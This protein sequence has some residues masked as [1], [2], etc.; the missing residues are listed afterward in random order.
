MLDDGVISPVELF[1]VNPAGAAVYVPPEKAPVPVKVTDAEFTVVQKG[2]PAYEMVAVGTA[3]M[4]TDAVAVTAAQPPE[5]A[6]VY[7]TV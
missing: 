4:I 5:A 1:I 3:V 6:L 7:V 2:V